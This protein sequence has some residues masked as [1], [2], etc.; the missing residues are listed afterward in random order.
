MRK[1][2]ALKILFIVFFFFFSISLVKA[3]S[4]EADS[5]TVDVSANIDVDL[6]SHL[7]LNPVTVEIK[8]NSQVLLEILNPDGTPKPNRDIEIYID[9]PSLGVTIGQPPSTDLNGETVGTVKSSIPG[10]Y[11][12][13]AKDV[14]NPLEI[15]I[16][17]CENLFVTP[18]PSPTMLPEPQYTAGDTNTVMWSMLNSLD[19]TYFAQISKVVGFSPVLS[20][21][22]WI[23]QLT[24]EFTGLSNGQI[25]F[26]RVKAKNAYGG[27][28]AWSNIVFSVQDSE[29]PSITILNIGSLGDNTVEEWDPLYS[30]II[31]LRVKDNVAIQSKEFW[32]V[33]S[34]DSPDDCKEGESTV[35]DIWEI[36]IKLGSLEQEDNGYLKEEYTFCAEAV[37]TVGNVRR[38]CNIKLEVDHKEG[39]IP[40]PPKTDIEKIIDKIIEVLDDTIGKIELDDLQDITVT[41]VV[42]NI[43]IGMG[44][45]IGSF[46]SIPYL[47]VQVILN[48]LTL[49]GFRKKGHPTGY[50]YDS[51]TKE[52][53]VQAIVRIFNSSNQLVWTDVTD[54]NGYFR[55]DELPKG[56]YAIRVTAKDYI[57]PSKIV[58]GN[59]DFPLENV[60]HG[61]EFRYEGGEIPN[62]SIPMDKVE[63]SQFRIFVEKLAFQSR[64]I[65][66]ILHIL[67]FLIG[68]IFSIY[69]VK[70][71]PIWF[72]Y[73]I[74]ILYIPSF[75]SVVISIFSKKERYGIVRNSKGKKL[76]GIIVGLKDKEFDKLI[77][78]RVTDR[79]GRYRFIVNKGTYNIEVL[80]TNLAIIDYTGLDN[81]KV[82]DGSVIAKDIK[83]KKIVEGEGGEEVIEPLSEL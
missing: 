38:I 50:V 3:E 76:K 71:S 40:K 23:P 21:S 46:N 78:K 33:L 20:S 53:I 68:L 70:I 15:Y 29:K 42:T 37:D 22:G 74:L 57:F 80:N 55:V 9:G 75:F 63:Y 41:T 36:Q 25:Y 82:K 27:E 64:G 59:K 43:T 28:S 73:L 17:D 56:I 81:I 10:S 45:L 24:Y 1:Y 13:C 65:L 52:P 79:L 44:I 14:T 7:T 39:A 2:T 31:R 19:Y 35:G 66:K 72:N 26:Y 60:Y 51:V 6:Y 83:V 77:S 32:C 5:F 69:A 61:K 4:F 8:E 12:V 58:F 67:L 49:L 62:Y 11:K 47:I 18:V 34:D 16:L 54:S 48:I 30:F